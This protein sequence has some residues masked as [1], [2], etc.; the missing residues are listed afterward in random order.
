MRAGLLTI[1]TAMAMLPALVGTAQA[2]ITIVNQA[3][4][5]VTFNITPYAGPGQEVVAAVI[6]GQ[7]EVLPGESATVPA[8]LHCGQS[9]TIG[10]NA[11]P[12]VRGWSA[13]CR[14]EG[15]SW[16]DGRMSVS[17]SARGLVCAP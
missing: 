8:N 16:T 15:L 9:A 1:A 13:Y 14:V 17:G 2:D 12:D 3:D 5:K 6:C 7:H 10:A 11:E 4:V